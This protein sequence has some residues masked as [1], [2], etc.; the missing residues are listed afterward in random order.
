MVDVDSVVLSQPHTCTMPMLDWLVF[1]PS[2]IVTMYAN[3]PKLPA[4]SVN[5]SDVAPGIMTGVPVESLYHWYVSPLP[6]AH[7]GL[8][9]TA[10]NVM[11]LPYIACCN[12]GYS[13]IEGMQPHP[14]WSNVVALAE[15]AT[16]GTIMT[17]AS[18]S[19][20]AR[21]ATLLLAPLVSVRLCIYTPSALGRFCR[22]SV[23]F[24][25][26]LAEAVLPPLPLE[27][28]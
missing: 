8:V 14:A 6:H 1:T 5:V 17:N 4:V 7:P 20:T 10:L 18:A 19:A 23:H 15:P 13:A 21:I 2:L 22:T 25:H 28:Y 3:P 12:C 27:P 24:L 16:A 26:G 11:G 9:T